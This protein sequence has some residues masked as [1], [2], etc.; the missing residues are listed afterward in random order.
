MREQEKGR[1]RESESF[2]P[3]DPSF[4]MH[5]LIVRPSSQEPVFNICNHSCWFGVMMLHA[6]S[7][8]LVLV[9]AWVRP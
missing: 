7:S 8:L 6:F 4:E 1:E 3:Q 9:L 2:R 5:V